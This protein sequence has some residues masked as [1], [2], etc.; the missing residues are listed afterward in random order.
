[1]ATPR[2]WAQD[3]IACYLCAKPTQSYCNTCQVTLC[4]KCARKHTDNFRHSSHNIVPFIE[5]EIELTF[6]SCQLHPGE[7]CK[8]HCRK[9]NK[10]VCNKCSSY[11]THAGHDVMK[12]EKRVEDKKK[13][14]EKEMDRIISLILEY[15]NIAD[16]YDSRISNVISKF[17]DLE[18]D[19][20]M[21][22]QLWHEEV[23]SMF[24]KLG[25]LMQ[26]LKNKK[27]YALAKQ[28]MDI[29]TMISDMREKVEE[30]KQ[31]L[32]SYN[33]STVNAYQLKFKEYR[34]PPEIDISCLN[35][36]TDL[37]T[38]SV[39]DLNLEGFKAML[40]KVS[41]PVMMGNINLFSTRKLLDE[42][43][44]IISIPTE[45]KPLFRVALVGNNEA[46]VS[47]ITN[48]ITRVDV[49]GSKVALFKS[50]CQEWPADI[51]TSQQ[52]ELIYTDDEKG[53]VHIVRDGIIETLITTP[54]D[55]K[56]NSIFCSRFGDIVVH[57]SFMTRNKIVFYNGKY[58]TQEIDRDELGFP[59]F[60]EGNYSL[61]MTENNN[62]DICVSDSNANIVVVL[63]RVGSVRF[64]YDGAL[65]NRK[66]RFGPKDV[67]TDSLSH[68]IVSDYNNDSLHILD[69]NGKLL[70]CIDDCA[71]FNPCGLSVDSMERL[72][73]ALCHSGEI[74]VLEYLTNI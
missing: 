54:K 26:Y 70:R 35:T 21:Q 10:P 1:M 33:V 51:A 65:A 45:Q 42:A 52:G 72:W 16:N 17:A 60:K 13:K 39:M 57:I 24:D 46:W 25:F 61:R 29:L 63:D 11:G 14:I 8:D 32:Q 74:K 6:L 9:C 71:L 56:P 58:I 15:Q 41:K 30:S 69:H 67:V 55:W 36:L 43:K 22:R 31:I 28:Q 64:R 62:G 2:S 44:E 23:D 48:T 38:E 50:T 47:G 18:Q 68:I 19:M 5:E 12:F 4:D 3:A 53:T 59:I 34:E 20:K 27:F 40:E 37:E 49:Q 7:K 73:V 66:N